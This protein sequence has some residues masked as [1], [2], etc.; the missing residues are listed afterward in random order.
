MSSS[1]FTEEPDYFQLRERDVGR[2]LIVCSD[3]YPGTIGW[4][5]IDNGAVLTRELAD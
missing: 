5:R 2:V 3:P 4:T 1:R